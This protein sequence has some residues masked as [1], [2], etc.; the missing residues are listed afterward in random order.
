MEGMLQ[1]ILFRQLLGLLSNAMAEGQWLSRATQEV[2]SD[3][4]DR[5]F[6]LAI[7]PPADNPARR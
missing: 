2:P 5:N 4:T 1:L 6:V 7:D 3:G